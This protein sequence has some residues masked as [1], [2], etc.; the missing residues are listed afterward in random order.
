[1]KRGRSTGSD[2][3]NDKPK[4]D[5]DWNCSDCNFSNFARN[6]ECFKCHQPKPKDAKR[7]SSSGGWGGGKDNGGGGGNNQ[8]PGDWTCSCGHSNYAFRKECQKCQNEKPAGA[9]DDNLDENG[10]KKP[11][12]QTYIPRESSESDM[13]E[14]NIQ[15]GKNFGAY[16]KIQVKV[17]G[18]DVPPPIN[19]FQSSGLHP[20]ILDVLNNRMKYDRPTPVQRHGIAIGLAKRDMM[21]CSQTG[22]GKTAAFLLPIIHDILKNNIPA[23]TYKPVA[24]II[25]PTRELA[26]QVGLHNFHN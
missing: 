14:T 19:D 25:S 26:N 2:G 16:D 3:N 6:R 9:G 12:R 13:F 7:D 8:R 23:V 21:A 22:S 18:E 17:N 20:H 5:G 11:P 24:V 4:R 10:E 1:M 15:T